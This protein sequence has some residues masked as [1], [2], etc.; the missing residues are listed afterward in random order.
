[1]IRIK[2]TTIISPEYN[3]VIIIRQNPNRNVKVSHFDVQPNRRP[4]T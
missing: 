2:I 1:M 3:T 4:G